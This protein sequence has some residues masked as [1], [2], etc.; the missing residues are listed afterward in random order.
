M[1]FLGRQRRGKIGLNFGWQ[2]AAQQHLRIDRTGQPANAGGR[3]RKTVLIT[4][5]GQL[6]QIGGELFPQSR[7][8]FPH[9]RQPL[10]IASLD[11]AA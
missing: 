6:I 3:F 11:L 9:P 7:M 2:R 1:P 8:L 4:P 10:Q 5:A